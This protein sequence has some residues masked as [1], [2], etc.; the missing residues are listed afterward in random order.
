MPSES[1]LAALGIRVLLYT[2]GAYKLVRSFGEYRSRQD[3]RALIGFVD[4]ITIL[5]AMSA[6]TFAAPVIREWAGP[7][8]DWPFRVLT[9]T[10]VGIFIAGLAFSVAA[11]RFARRA[12]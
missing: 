2:L 12:A 6:F 11:P 10:S 8:L 9:G 1:V 4:A 7:A 3:A 5:A